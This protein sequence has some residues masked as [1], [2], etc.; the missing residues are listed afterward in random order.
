MRNWAELPQDVLLV[1]LQKLIIGKDYH[2]FAFVCRSWTGV[3]VN[4]LER[5]APSGSPCLIVPAP[6][7]ASKSKSRRLLASP[8][9]KDIDKEQDFLP[10]VRVPL[11]DVYIGS[12]QGW[13]IMLTDAMGMYLLN[14]ISDTRI[15]LPEIWLLE[16]NNIYRYTIAMIYLEPMWPRLSFCRSKVI[17]STIPT[18][19]DCFVLLIYGYKKLA[20]CKVGDEDWTFIDDKAFRYRIEKNF[21]F[22]MDAIYLKGQFYVVSAR[23]EIFGFDLTVSEPKLTTMY[24][25]GLHTNALIHRVPSHDWQLLWYLVEC[26]GQ[27]FRILQVEKRRIE[28]E[29][30]VNQAEAIGIG[31]E[32]PHT[33]LDKLYC[34]VSYSSYCFEVCKLDTRSGSKPSWIQVDN[35][36]GDAVFL[37][38]NQSFSLSN[39][40]EFGYKRN[41]IYFTD[42][43]SVNN[44]MGVFNL[45][46]GTV[47]PLYK[48]NSRF[49]LPSAIWVIPK[50]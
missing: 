32:H 30:H 43:A 37:G 26:R 6:G 29:D 12:H 2:R 15:N 23:G 1:I 9:G 49:I 5:Y 34:R 25:H 48:T 33:P 27:L 38:R 8:V 19:S 17:L 40:H 13:L 22:F 42:H 45:E 11:Q 21:R 20:F 3:V 18:A 7:I 39:P 28:E 41:R 16:L 36:E 50:P 10:Q 47:E 24:A 35:F 31:A 4:Y 14:P 44:D 46:D